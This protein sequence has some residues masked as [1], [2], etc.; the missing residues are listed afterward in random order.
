MAFLIQDNNGTVVGANSYIPVAYLQEYLADRAR[1]DQ[2]AGATAEQLQAAIIMATA[3][4]DGRF[5]FIG[6]RQ[7]LGLQTTQ[8]PRFDAIDN[9]YAYI[10]DIPS[11][12]KD[13]TCEYAVRALPG[14]LSTP[15]TNTLNPD[16]AVSDTGALME[17]HIVRVGPIEEAQRFSGAGAYRM[18]PYPFADMI[19]KKRGLVVMGNTLVRAA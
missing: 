2:I 16:P 19:L 17:E 7:N 12:V 13:A 9:D 5:Q 10:Q 6:W 3:Y 15:T 4:L 1:S 18:P 8:W 14:V 11:E